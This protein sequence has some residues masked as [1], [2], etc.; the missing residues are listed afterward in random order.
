MTSKRFFDDDAIAD[1]RARDA[2]QFVLCERRHSRA[3]AAEDD[4]DADAVAVRVMS[5]KRVAF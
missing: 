3:E 4:A 2:A 5:K 1:A